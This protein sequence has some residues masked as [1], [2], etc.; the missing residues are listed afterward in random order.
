LFNIMVRRDSSLKSIV[1][2]GGMVSN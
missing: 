1:E 2:T